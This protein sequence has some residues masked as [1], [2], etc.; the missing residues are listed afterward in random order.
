MDK[1]EKEIARILGIKRNQIMEWSTG[2][3][4][5]QEGEELVHVE[6]LGVNVAYKIQIK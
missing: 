3:V 2:E 1:I 4:K 6:E 5:A